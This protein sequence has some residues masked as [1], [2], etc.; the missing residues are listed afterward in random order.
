MAIK[1]TVASGACV[2]FSA[3]RKA[4]RFTLE[5]AT[6]VHSGQGFY[7]GAYSVRPEIEA[8]V[9]PTKQKT[10]SDDL[11]VQ[12]IPFH[13]F[14]NGTGQTVVIGGTDIGLQ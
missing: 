3:E 8:Q 14:S 2:T 11:T 13:E 10:M 4:E 7:G 5:K 12:G 1:F 6:I 9:L